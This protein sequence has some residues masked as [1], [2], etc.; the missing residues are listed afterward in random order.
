MKCLTH[1]GFLKFKQK[2]GD[3]LFEP[4]FRCE[5]VYLQR[6]NPFE[7]DEPFVISWTVAF[8]PFL[9]DVMEPLQK[10]MKQHQIL[11]HIQHS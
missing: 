3:S 9:G 7:R 8:P 10:L 4:G 6:L 2:T 5:E 11:L 1:T